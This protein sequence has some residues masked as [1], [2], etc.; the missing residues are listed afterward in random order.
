MVSTGVANR[1]PTAMANGLAAG[2]AGLF[3]A[4]VCYGLNEVLRLIFPHAALR[5]PELLEKYRAMMVTLVACLAIYKCIFYV[6]QLRVVLLEAEQ[7]KK[8][9]VESQLE[10]LDRH[11]YGGQGL[12]SGVFGA[13]T[14]LLPHGLQIRL[15]HEPDPRQARIFARSTEITNHQNVFQQAYNPR[16]NQNGTA[17]K[18]GFLPV[19]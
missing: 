3:S 15:P 13:A 8:V 2:F 5:R 6:K 9:N 11:T 4:F 1:P 18:Q 10:T 12:R 19:P 16:T 14:G 17:Y 7:I